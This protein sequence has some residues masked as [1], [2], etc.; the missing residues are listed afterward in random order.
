MPADNT[1]PADSQFINVDEST[2]QAPPVEQPATVPESKTP[3]D[4]GSPKEFSFEDFSNLV[5]NELPET[6]PADKPADAPTDPDATPDE[7]PAAPELKTKPAD[8]PDTKVP[9]KDPPVTPPS[10]SRDYSGL[11]DDVVPLFKK[12][13][14]NAFNKLKPVYQEHK[15]LKQ[16]VAEKEAEIAKLREG[17]IPD[18]YYEHPRG[19]TL[20][21]E[22]EEAATL[23]SKANQ[24]VNHWQEQLERVRQGEE[25]YQELHIN[26]ENGQFYLSAPI[27]ADKS[28]E[29]VVSRYLDMSRAQA[30]RVL[31]RIQALGIQHE[32]TYK[33]AIQQVQD[34]EKQS[35]AIFEKP[36]LAKSLG[37]IV[38]DTIKNVLPPA[39]HN[40]PLASIVAKSLFVVKQ[41]GDAN[42]KLQEQLAGKGGA[43]ATATTPPGKKADEVD[44]RI[45]PTNSDMSAGGQGGNTQ[46]AVSWESYKEYE[47]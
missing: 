33:Q 38:K 26:P 27:K 43:T 9:P 28:S 24:I 47:R 7:T 13:G 34:F 10:D 5:T 31:G 22:F 17:R 36:E 40:N 1:P 39:F 30:Q 3:A 42:K 12:M 37:P 6:K 15:A 46:T 19:Y 35:F 11:E 21:P 8:V 29:Q 20:T 41:L 23:N 4:T 16:S 45:N 14:N 32:T 25:T 18:S 2:P 44:T